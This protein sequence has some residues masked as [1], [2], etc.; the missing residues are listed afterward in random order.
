MSKSSPFPGG[1]VLL[2]IGHLQ[3]ITLV[4]YTSKT[5]EV[6]KLAYGTWN[7]V[8]EI[9]GTELNTAYNGERTCIGLPCTLPTIFDSKQPFQLIIKVQ[10]SA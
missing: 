4:Q 2:Y 6:Y 5:S 1:L 3:G 8:T 9:E 7:Y 10:S